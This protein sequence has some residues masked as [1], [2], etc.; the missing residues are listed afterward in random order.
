MDFGLVRNVEIEHETRALVGTPGYLA[1][2]LAEDKPGS[3]TSFLTDI[4]SFG[5]TAFEL[6]TGTLPFDGEGWIEIIRK[7]ITE[8]PPF[9]SETRP[10]LPDKVD[11]MVFRA[12]SKDPKER[13]ANCGELLEDLY[14]IA[15]STLP[16]N[17]VIP[18]IINKGTAGR[19]SSRRFSSV[20]PRSSRSTA[21][22]RARLLVVDPD[23]EFRSRVHEIAKATVPG[24]RV[25]SATGG[26][27]ALKM[28]EEVRPTALILDLNLPEINGL[29]VVATLRGD[30]NNDSVSIIV[31][32]VKG[33]E[34]DAAILRQLRVNRYLTKPVDR[35]TLAEELRPILERPISSS[36]LSAS[37]PKPWP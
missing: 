16:R 18:Y 23:P 7:H 8:V 20:P 14:Q 2:E 17:D 30:T 12:L 27:M 21:S 19:R 37:S 1:P 22:S 5:V 36:R 4:Y 3:D 26:A 35:D 6:F 25:F 29:E 11:E 34:R 28:F 32:S 24:C 10:G 33:G 31:A 9:P 15:Q 13:H